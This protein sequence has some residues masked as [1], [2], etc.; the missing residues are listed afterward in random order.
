[1]RIPKG[2]AGVI[3]VMLSLM[4]S[5]GA[6][7]LLNGSSAPV[8]VEDY[9]YITDVSGL[10]NY[11]TVPAY[12]NYSPAQNNYQYSSSLADLGTYS[13]GIYYSESK[14]ANL[15]PIITPESG[16]QTV[17]STIPFNDVVYWNL[18]HG[19]SNIFMAYKPAGT[20]TLTLV[21]NELRVDGSI[22]T[23]VYGYFFSSNE[24]SAYKQGNGSYFLNNWTSGRESDQRIIAL[25]L[26][27]SNN[28]VSGSVTYE[29]GAVVSNSKSIEYFYLADNAGGYCTKYSSTYF[30]LL[31]NSGISLSAPYSSGGVSTYITYNDGEL[32]FSNPDVSGSVSLTS[33]LVPDTSNVRM[34]DVLGFQIAITKDGLTQTLIPERFIVP[35]NVVTSFPNEIERGNFAIATEKSSTGILWESRF[36]TTKIIRADQF[37]VWMGG[38]VEYITINS[39]VS[40][41]NWGTQYSGMSSLKVQNIGIAVD[42]GN[43]NVKEALSF[44][45]REQVNAAYV[46]AGYSPGLATTATTPFTSHSAMSIPVGIIQNIRINGNNTVE[47]DYTYNSDTSHVIKKADECYLYFWQT[48]T[49]SYPGFAAVP[50]TMS[51]TMSSYTGVKFLDATQGVSLSGSVAFWSNDYELGS[52]SFM[53]RKPTTATS[54]QFT[55]FDKSGNTLNAWTIRFDQNWYLTYSTPTGYTTVNLGSSWPAMMITDYYTGELTATPVKSFTNF[56]SYRLSSATNYDTSYTGNTSIDHYKIMKTGAGLRMAVVGTSVLNGTVPGA[57]FNAT[58][59]AASYFPNEENIRIAFDSAAYVG[60]NVTVGTWTMDIDS[61]SFYGRFSIEDQ[62]YKVDLTQPWSLTWNEDDTVSI[63]FT[64]S[65]RSG[66]KS[67]TILE[68]RVT[69]SIY[70]GGQWAIDTDAYSVSSHVED[71]YDFN[72]GSWGLD[73]TTF[74]VCVMGLTAILAIAFKLARVDFGLID[75][76]VLFGANAIMWLVL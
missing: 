7:F 34:T 27:I 22:I 43:M 62:E 70:L 33:T 56:T 10:Y 4:G 8:V 19:P 68:S 54:Y 48:D 65:K 23:G 15:N 61:A 5:I 59:N 37:L 52:A 40:T 3:V 16:L 30:Y 76:I 57:M 53:F 1:M 32:K 67:V 49:E 50:N 12:T 35:D 13:S 11:T 36:I 38:G 63:E 21:N 51:Y 60:S 28:V 18:G 14:A 66:Q 25:N 41:V 6:G 71:Q 74:I 31:G 9:D 44:A 75:F 46:T 39:P 20:H 55:S 58:F 42:A 26:T 2:M 47:Y 72:F 45:N 64:E 24:F 29:G 73:K 69:P 17:T